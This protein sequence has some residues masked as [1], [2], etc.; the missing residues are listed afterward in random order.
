VS[1][2]WPFVRCVFL[3]FFVPLCLCGEKSS[4]VAAKAPIATINHKDTKLTKYAQYSQ[5]KEKMADHPRSAIFRS[6]S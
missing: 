2:W 5:Q 4:P 6:P 3:L 1:L